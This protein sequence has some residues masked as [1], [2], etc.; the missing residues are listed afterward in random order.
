MSI[1]KWLLLSAAGF[2]AAT[3]SAVLAGG[4]DQVPQSLFTPAIYVDAHGGYSFYNW[5]A[6]AG[7][8][9]ITIWFNRAMITTNKQ[10]GGMG[11]LD[12]GMQIFKNVAFEVGSFYLP[13]VE[14]VGNIDPCP[15]EEICP[16]NA[17]E[18]WNWMV[19]SALRFD[20]P[21]PYVNGLNVFAKVGPGWR[22]MSNVGQTIPGY[23]GMRDY[24]TVV[25][26]A[27]ADYAIRQSGFRV[28]VQ[29]LHVP[30]YISVSTLAKAAS[31]QPAQN[32]LTASV[33]YKYDF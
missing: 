26:G 11:G 32:L 19:Y 16:T 12:I 3:S 30:G 1:K 7:A 15:D 5:D 18:Q 33:G 31:M 2:I 6:L 20:V 24:W 4:P 22:G 10:G 21:M 23:G 9:D 13:R 29:W 8:S 14:G 27:G 17:A 25:F 28:G